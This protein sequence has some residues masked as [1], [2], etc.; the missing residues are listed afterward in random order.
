MLLIFPFLEIFC[1][2]SDLV[3][4]YV[5][6]VSFLLLYVYAPHLPS[7][8]SL[9]VGCALFLRDPV[10][11]NNAQKDL[12]VKPLISQYYLPIREGKN[13]IDSLIDLIHFQDPELAIIFASTKKLVDVIY[14][15]MI[16]RFDCNLL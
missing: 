12:A 7:F 9:R 2:G 16:G 3:S 1:T 5:L 6:I 10:F 8:Y 13:K 4:T 14:E 11:I 15:E